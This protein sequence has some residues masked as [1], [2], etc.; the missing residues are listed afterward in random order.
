MPVVGFLN[1]GSPEGAYVANLP[2][3]L[4]GL[5]ETGYVDGKT[6]RIEYR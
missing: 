5:K 6:V 3:F 4:Q 2:G 1:G